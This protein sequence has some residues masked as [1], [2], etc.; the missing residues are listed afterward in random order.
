MRAEGG[1]ERVRLLRLDGQ[2]APY[3]GEIFRGCS[4]IEPYFPE[5]GWASTEQG[6]VLMTK[7]PSPIVCPACAANKL[8]QS[9]LH[10]DGEASPYAVS[11][12]TVYR[13]CVEIE[14]LGSL[15]RPLPRGAEEKA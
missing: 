11:V 2:R 5:N 6:S 3:F 8:D 7:A 12:I 9:S 13:H 4:R 10:F 1:Q 15:T 14:P